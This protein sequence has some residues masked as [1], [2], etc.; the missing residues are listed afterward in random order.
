METFLSILSWIIWWV[1]GAIWWL[2]TQL[3]WLLLWLAL[4]LLV[5]AFVAFRAAGYLL[6]KPVVEAWLRRHA[7]CLCA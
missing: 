6:G 3:L 2:L 4:P 7:A 5:I 1:L